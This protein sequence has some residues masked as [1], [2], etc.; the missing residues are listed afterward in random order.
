MQFKA[1]WRSTG[2]KLNSF[3]PHSVDKRWHVL[4]IV[5]YYAFY[6]SRRIIGMEMTGC[7]KYETY[8]KL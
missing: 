6:I 5:T 4:G 8:L 7:G 3:A 1:D 2:Q